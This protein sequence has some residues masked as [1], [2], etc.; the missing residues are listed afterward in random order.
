[1]DKYKGPLADLGLF[2][3]LGLIGWA[4]YLYFAKDYGWAHW[5]GFGQYTPPNPDTERAKTL[6]DFLDL[7]LMPIVGPIIVALSVRQ[8][9][10][11]REAEHEAAMIQRRADLRT[12][13]ERQQTMSLDAYLDEMSVLLLDKGLRTSLRDSEI[14]EIARMRTLNILR[15]INGDRKGQIMQFLFEAELIHIHDPIVSLS[16]ADL[17]EANL[18]RS[19]LQGANLYEAN[20]QW[21]NLEE[22]DLRGANLQGANLT[23]VDLRRTNLREANLQE[24]DLHNANLWRA[25][26]RGA[27]LREADLQEADLQDADVEQAD[28]STANLAKANLSGVRNLNIALIPYGDPDSAIQE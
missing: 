18:R 24:T 14:R 2:L 11:E 19:E 15:R 17:R 10:K 3:V 13:Q 25:D 23:W 4:I 22:A 20:L 26:L 7:I 28:L 6:W 8:L 5:T 27:D 12:E 21:A 1:L 9:T 16:G